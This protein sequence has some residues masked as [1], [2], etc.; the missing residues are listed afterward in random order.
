MKKRGKAEEKDIKVKDLK[1]FWKWLWN[2]DSIWSWV[3]FFIL[4]FI[5]IRVVFFSLASFAT[6]STLRFVVIESCSMN[7]PGF[8]GDFEDWWQDYGIWYEERNITKE[9]FQGFKYNTG[10]KMGDIIVVSKR[11]EINI[12]DVAIFQTNKEAVSKRPIIHRVIGLE[13]L[14]TKGDYNSKQ[15]TLTNNAYK[16]DETGITQEQVIGKAVFKIPRLGWVKLIF[17]K[18]YEMFAGVPQSMWC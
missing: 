12:G 7:H 5:L 18:I 15:L 4:A 6:G 16:I 8:L 1:S 13:P 14:A 3:V 17:V 2:S 9:Q 11:S 10:M